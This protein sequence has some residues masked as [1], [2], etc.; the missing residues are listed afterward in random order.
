MKRI[1]ISIHIALL[2]IATGCSQNSEMKKAADQVENNYKTPQEA[3]NYAKANLHMILN[4]SQIKSF[5][6]GSA[7]EIKQL[8]VTNEVPLLLLPMDQLKDSTMKTASDAIVYALGN[9]KSPKI[10]ISV[11]NPS[12]KFWIISTIGLKK[13][14]DALA[15]QAGVTGIVEVMGLEI[16]LLEIQADSVKLYKPVADYRGAKI[17]QDRTYQAAEILQS[18]EAYRAELERKFGK[19]FS[20]G[21]IEM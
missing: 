21:N 9:E 6:L 2:L 11:R 14:S 1:I 5:G 13:Y 12:G 4:E 17:Y 7:E 15:N 10:C 20:T 8:V 19:D 16:S 3:F 18:L